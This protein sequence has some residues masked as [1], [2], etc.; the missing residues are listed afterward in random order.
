MKVLIISQSP[1]HITHGGAEV[2]AENLAVSLASHGVNVEIAT[3]VPHKY[4]DTK[5]SFDDDHLPLKR[6]LIPS[7]ATHPFFINEDPASVQNWLKTAEEANADVIHFHHFFR[8]GTNVL[9]QINNLDLSSISILT[10]HEYLAICLRD[11]QLVRTSGAQ[12]SDRSPL[13]CLKCNQSSLIDGGLSYI[14]SRNEIFKNL[15]MSMDHLIAP[16]SFLMQQFVDWEI[17]PLQISQIPN[18]I[19]APTAMPSISTK[20]IK[21]IL[22]LSSLTKIKGIE[23]FIA[24]ADEILSRTDA[25]SD[26][27]FEIWGSTLPADIDTKFHK[28]LELR[29]NHI[30]LMGNY[31]RIAL[32]D[33]LSNS[34]LIVCP[35]LWFENR[36]TILDEAAIRS[37][38]TLSSNIGGMKELADR[39]LS[40]TFKVGDSFDLAESILNILSGEPAPNSS[41]LDFLDSKDRHMDLYRKIIDSKIYN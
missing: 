32:D 26:I 7:E 41:P 30:K 33:V 13:D 29:S 40:W 34:T 17:N 10:L 39:P 24:A 4:L 23:T 37:I 21:R 2:A 15:L 19:K 35:S 36:P 31:E 12:C 3:A 8:I 18:V 28:I 1:T 9:N 38:R 25:P 11:G 22:F 20:F 6:H 16:S 5:V 27:N 14:L